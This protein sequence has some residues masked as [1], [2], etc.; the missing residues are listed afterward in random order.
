MGLRK[1][2]SPDRCIITPKLSRRALQCVAGVVALLAAACGG[3]SREPGRGLG[4]PGFVRGFAGSVVADEPRAV[5][6]ARDILSSGGS[7][8]DAAVALYFT[9]AVTLPSTAGLGGGG[10][11]VVWDAASNRAEALDFVARAPVRPS[12]PADRPAAVAGNPRG[13]FALHARY[14]RLRWEQLVAPAEALARF[15]VPVSRALAADLARVGS[16]LIQDAE[17]RRLFARADGTL[18]AEGDSLVQI[19][20][21]A[22]LSSIRARTPADFYAGALAAKVSAAIEA[23]G[24]GVGAGDLRD[25][26]PAWRDTVKVRFGDS[27]AHFAPLPAV[28]SV[29][30]AQMWAA[31]VLGGRYARAPAEERDHLIAEIAMRSATDRERWLAR[32][33]TAAVPIEDIVGD[34][35]I[36][37]L[38]ADYRSDRH[39]PQQT[40]VA[41]ENP[42]AAAFVVVDN[43]GS[44]VSCGVTNN[45]LFGT[46]RVAAGTGIVIAAAPDA[47][48]RGPQSLAAMIAVRPTAGAFHF[49]GAA[50][51]GVVAPSAL[52]GT[53]LRAYVD[54]RPI[55]EALAALRVHNGGLS[56]GTLVESGMPDPRLAP[57]RL[58]GHRLREG[59]DAMGRV[60]AVS[61]RDGLP[62][63]AENTCQARADRRGLGFAIQAE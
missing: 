48:G 49:A 57:L 54:R 44:A 29:V 7:A 9:L 12:A 32:D 19:D 26:V 61:C 18:L 38:M 37:S 43:Q 11:C 41:A 58:R 51:G 10:M 3:G 55:E 62:T 47:A 25:S 52:V 6:A 46:G 5:L 1:L 22:V 20:L 34:A 53:G 28:A 59:V 30:T 24:G 36:A 35:R 33:L 14:G 45:N 2:Q 4:T 8:A 23:A 16:A 31:A 40:P 42:F 63:K 60:N 17:S 50:A 27:T 15:G 39:S 13:M 21:A 56:E